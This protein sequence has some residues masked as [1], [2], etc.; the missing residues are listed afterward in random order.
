M[1]T[2][3]NFKKTHMKQSL[4]SNYIYK[5]HFILSRSN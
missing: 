4:D 3:I 2:E 5:V 1:N